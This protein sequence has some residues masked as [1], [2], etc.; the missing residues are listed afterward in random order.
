VE[1]NEEQNETYEIQDY[2]EA[3]DYYN[4]QDELD[5][6]YEDSDENF[7]DYEVQNE[8]LLD[9]E[10]S[11]NDPNDEIE[12]D[13]IVDEAMSNEQLLPISGEF[14]PYFKNVTEA[15]MFCWIQKH[16]ICKI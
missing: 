11:N 1:D 7:F 8:E 13:T 15:L 6:S 5:T 16:N 4:M 12:P 10:E 3:Q 2:Y 9:V 14:A